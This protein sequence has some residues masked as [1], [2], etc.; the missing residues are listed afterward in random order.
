MELYEEKKTIPE[1][2]FLPFL[3]SLSCHSKSEEKMFSAMNFPNHLL[4][5]HKTILPSKK[6]S[7]E[8]KY[9]FCK[10]LLHHMKEEENFVLEFNESL[11][12]HP[13]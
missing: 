4:E 12:S 5:D 2:I 1:T 3:K 8:E 6:Y 10:S 13:L 9:Y 7:N 11:R